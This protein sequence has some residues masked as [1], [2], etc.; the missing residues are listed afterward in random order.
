MVGTLEAE[1]RGAILDAQPGLTRW[2]RLIEA[3]NRVKTGVTTP[4]WDAQSASV[5]KSHRLRSR[6]DAWQSLVILTA[7][8]PMAALMRQTGLVCSSRRALRAAAYGCSDEADGSLVILASAVLRTSGHFVPVQPSAAGHSSTLVARQK[9]PSKLGISSSAP[10][11]AGV[12]IEPTTSS[13][14]G[15]RYYHLSYPAIAPNCLDGVSE[16]EWW[17]MRGHHLRPW[18]DL[19]P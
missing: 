19:N 2:F 1:G 11:V 16:T 18:W 3:N 13:F 12:G 6:I 4:I 17:R 14:S 8:Q 15:M 7:L 5:G 10:R 9:C